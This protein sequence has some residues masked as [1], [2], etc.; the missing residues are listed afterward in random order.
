MAARPGWSLRTA[1]PARAITLMNSVSD[2]H[3]LQA[4][5]CLDWTNMA[6]SSSASNQDSQPLHTKNC[7]FLRNG[8]SCFRS[9]ERMARAWL[10]RSKMNL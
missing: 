9:V 6:S 5:A 3:R 8:G 2:V 10:R 4:A 1:S 7:E